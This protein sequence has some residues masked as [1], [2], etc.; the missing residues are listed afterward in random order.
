MK[1]KLYTLLAMSL[2]YTTLSPLDD[3]T[4]QT[5]MFV[6]PIFDSVSIQQAS[7]HNLVYNKQKYGAAVQVIG[8]Y[9]Q[10][11]ANL[12]NPSYFFFDFKN[13]LNISAGNNTAI[14]KTTGAGAFQEV[15]N[16][17]QGQMNVKSLNRDILGQ[18]IGIN[19]DQ[20]LSLSL[21]PQQ[22]QACALVEI[23]QDLKK[24]FSWSIF[25]NWFINASLP[26]TWIENNIGAHGDK[27]A[28]D[29]FN[30]PGWQYLNI[31][32][33]DRSSIRLTQATL[34]LGTKYQSENDVQIIT[35]SGVIVPLVEQP[36]NGSIFAPIQGFNSH[37]GFDTQVHFQFPIVKKTPESRSR[38]LMFIDIHNNFLSRNHQLRTYDIKGKPFSRYMKLLDRKTN[39]LIPAMNA[40]TIRSKV[41]PFN[42]VN[43]ATGFRFSHNDCFGEIG[44]EL[45]AH[46]SEV[47]TP[48]PKITQELGSWE[49][50]RYGIAFIGSDGNLAKIDAGGNVVPLALNEMGQTSS[51]STINYVA[52][53]D[54]EFSCCA[55]PTF[56]QKNKYLTLK[57]LNRQ[58]SAAR[59]T[60]THRAFF[61]VGCG[62][63]GKK[64]DCFANFGAFIEA[65]QNNAALNFWG[66]WLKAG[67]SF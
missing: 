52:A 28:I 32:N 6:R 47:I 65:A 58:T 56:L 10:S 38:I 2:G 35:S 45:W 62:Q 5:Y 37:F 14:F 23:S 55:T 15:S 49:D 61:S 34:S 33:G 12:F 26:V 20:N 21:D 25:E 40:L 57:D 67:V 30:Q 31:I 22:R 19:S 16:P 7:W 53:P 17:F 9:E 60:I 66:G 59:S 48:E 1:Y 44:Y 39:S 46:G 51:N 27:K 43:F 13:K 64:R 3:Y 24:L 11:Y 8:I 4:N 29:A 36:C 50:D 41:E 42:V 63:K 54:G 18:W